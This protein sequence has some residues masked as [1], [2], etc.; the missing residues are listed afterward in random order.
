M[1]SFNS[2]KSATRK[3][4]GFLKRNWYYI[5]PF[6]LI[7]FLFKGKLFKG[8][9]TMVSSW[10]GALS[11]GDPDEPTRT[12]V[13]KQQVAQTPVSTNLPKS[14]SY[15]TGIAETLYNSMKSFQPDDFTL[16]KDIYTE[17]SKLSSDELKAIYKAFGV[18]QDY[19]FS[20]IDLGNMDLIGWFR[21]ELHDTWYNDWMTNMK[22]I[23]SKTGLWV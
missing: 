19:M 21:Q 2:L 20:V 23:W 18:R 4:G 16:S 8:V 12:N 3:G 10:T 9:G 14:A 1:T 15:Y 11:V 13:L 17:L 22:T 5:L 6:I 7:A